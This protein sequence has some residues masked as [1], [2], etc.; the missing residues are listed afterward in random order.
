[1]AKQE[2]ITVR[3]QCG[4]CGGTKIYVGLECHDGAGMVCANCEGKGWVPITYTPFIAPKKRNDVKRV[5]EAQKY[6]TF[7]PTDHTFEDGKTVNYSEFGCTYEEW[8]NGA[9]PKPWPKDTPIE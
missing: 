7:Y 4:D 1:M 5:F 3:A 9:T 6:R 2:K 8:E